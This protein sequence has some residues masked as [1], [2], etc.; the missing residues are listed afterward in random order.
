MK[1]TLYS[2]VD[3]MLVPETLSELIGRPVKSVRY[4]PADFGGLSGSHLS[5]VDINQGEEPRYVLKHI[6]AKQDW[7]MRVTDDQLGREVM[8]WQHGLLD[9]LSPEV[10]HAIIACAVDGAGWAILM[11]DV[12]LSLLESPL[13]RSQNQTCLEALA[14]IHAAFWQ[15][16]TLTDSALGL[17]DLKAYLAWFTPA[18]C[19]P[20]LGSHFMVKAIV[21]GWERM[22]RVI[23]PDIAD[24]IDELLEDP[25]PLC[26]ALSHYPH[27]LIHGDYW[28]HNVGLQWQP[29]QQVILLDWQVAT[30]APPA[31][32]LVWWL[33]TSTGK[34]PVSPEETI[35][36][37]EHALASRLG[38]QFSE[39]WWQPQLDLCLFAGFLRVGWAFA[40]RL[41]DD[42]F[43][44]VR[45]DWQ[46]AADWWSERVRIG[47]KWL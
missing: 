16:P 6:S 2:S 33:A 4:T 12:S 22:N 27:T 45:A 40:S 37:Y 28:V 18:Q 24:I 10:D 8:L 19:R 15:N 32:D 25:Q 30:V 3:A 5:V 38:P 36:I 20:E 35:A 21:D 1:N 42:D 34:L 29:R 9:Q 44:A 11:H 26:A 17:N 7:I 43:E 13:S 14:A 39:D 46:E 41:L 23:Q 47:A 31:T